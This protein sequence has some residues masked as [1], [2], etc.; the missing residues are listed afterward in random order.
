MNKSEAMVLAKNKL[1]E[2]Q[3]NELYSTFWANYQEYCEEYCKEEGIALVENRWGGMDIPDEVWDS[4]LPSYEEM[5][6][7]CAAEEI[8]NPCYA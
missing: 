4:A 7:E 5:W 1:K 3:N 8:L 2:N 6:L